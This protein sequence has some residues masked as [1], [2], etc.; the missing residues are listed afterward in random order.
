MKSIKDVQVCSSRDVN[1]IETATTSSWFFFTYLRV[2]TELSLKT[3]Q[4][5][6]LTIY[7]LLLS[8]CDITNI[9]DNFPRSTTGKAIHVTCNL[10]SNGMEFTFPNYKIL[11]I[12]VQSKKFNFQQIVYFMRPVIL[13]LWHIDQLV[14][15]LKKITY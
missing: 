15:S 11:S 12:C 3:S 9:T 10:Q 1:V 13:I 4:A 8:T 7:Y 14:N 6:T 2:W 5:Y